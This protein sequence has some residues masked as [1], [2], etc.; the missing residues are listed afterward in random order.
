MNMNDSSFKH[1]KFIRN[2]PPH[3]LTSHHQVRYSISHLTWWWLVNQKYLRAHK[4]FDAVYAK[5]Y[6]SFLLQIRILI[7]VGEIYT[8]NVKV[9]NCVLDWFVVVI[10]CLGNERWHLQLMSE[11]IE[12]G[13]R[14]DIVNDDYFLPD[15]WASRVKIEFEPKMCKDESVCDLF[16]QG[17][18]LRDGIFYAIV[19]FEIDVKGLTWF[20]I[21]GSEGEVWLTL[22]WSFSSWLPG[23]RWRW[24][25]CLWREKNALYELNELWHGISEW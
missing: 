16:W 18:F 25:S 9:L 24:F 4:L 2:H 23:V 20:V 7:I 22:S 14:E 3:P 13:T 10:E 19:V 15:I 11:R 6:Y 1:P 12:F 8:R 17:Q 21:L 5:I